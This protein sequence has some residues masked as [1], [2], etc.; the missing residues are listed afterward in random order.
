MRGITEEVYAHTRTEYL[1]I[2]SQFPHYDATRERDATEWAPRFN[3]RH[4]RAV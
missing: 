3:G 1:N 2:L 4:C